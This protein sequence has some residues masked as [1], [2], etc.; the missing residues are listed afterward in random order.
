VENFCA[1]DGTR[2]GWVGERGDWVPKMS[3][4]IAIATCHTALAQA[5]CNVTLLCPLLLLGATAV[6]Y[7]QAQSLLSAC[8]MWQ[9]QADTETAC[10]DR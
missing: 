2:Q 5:H 3:L 7:C 10:P 9:V 4:L 1:L 6:G 8:G